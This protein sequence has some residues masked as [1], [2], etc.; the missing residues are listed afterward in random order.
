[1]TG[2]AQLPPDRDMLAKFS[3][4]MFKHAGTEGYV[5]LRAFYEDDSTKPFR[6]TPTSMKGG[7]PFLIEAAEDDANR[8]A[9]NP[10]KVVFCPPVAIFNNR[11]RARESDILAGLALSVEC[12]QRPLEARTMLE[13]I[14]GPAT[15]VVR[16]GGVWT[17]PE[18]G[19][20]CD[21]LHLHWRLRIPARGADLTTLKQARDLATRLVGGDP[22]NK[23]VC[24][25]IRWPGSWHRKSEPRLC[26]IE[27]ATEH[28][29][30]LATALA[31]LEKVAPAAAPGNGKA[32]GHDA[33][34][35][36]DWA[37]LISGIVTGADYHGSEIK[38]AS[39]MLAAGMSAG[40]AVNMLRGIFASSTGPRDARWQ[41]RYDDIPRSVTTAQE[42]CG[43]PGAPIPASPTASE[44]LRDLV[45]NDVTGGKRAVTRLAG[46]LLRRYVDPHV[47]LELLMTWNV[48]RC[49]PPLA[50]P[51]ITTIVNW[52][53]G[54]ELA[55]RQAK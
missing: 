39:K 52:I 11:E 34:P 25:P 50:P 18:S 19:E 33:G 44:P 38:L 24:H 36:K 14:L 41:A 4:A 6:I 27:T 20:V 26:K 22:S 2:R 5:S 8:A 29:I 3:A 45:R 53:A 31:A 35:G 51:E 55:R 54:R 10:R 21:K 1:M 42:K 40:A 16:S 32:N 23:P 13:E 28:E 49:S 46:H 30:D 9:N 37:E 43:T 15:L 17:D 47:A 48:A 12:D 7:L